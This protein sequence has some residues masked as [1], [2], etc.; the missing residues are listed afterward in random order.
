MGAV[1]ISAA[2]S[3]VD[4]AAACGGAC[5][6]AAIASS[7]GLPLLDLGLGVAGAFFGLAYTP[8]VHWGK[9]LDIPVGRPQWVSVL[10]WVRRILMVA[11]L[12]SATALVMTG[13][14]QVIQHFPLMG[15][16]G[17]IPTPTRSL[18]LSFVGQYL[19]PRGFRFAG[20]WVDNRERRE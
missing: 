13:F 15:W 2:A 7:A 6:A 4:Q 14:A 19:I 11:F 1:M 3:R 5:A 20:R 16:W 17:P 12:L 9:W 10:Y 18:L 8:P